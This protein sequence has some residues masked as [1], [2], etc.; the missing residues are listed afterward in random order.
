MMRRSRATWKKSLVW[1][2]KMGSFA[3]VLG[4][5]GFPAHAVCQ[6][7]CIAGT[8]QPVCASTLDVPPVC[9]PRVCPIPSPSVRPIPTILVPPI[10]TTHCAPS[11]VLNEETQEYVWETLC[12]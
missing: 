4:T 3:L 8:V 2:G 11:Y 6:C 5:S 7:V 1:A 10:G 12:R 9:T